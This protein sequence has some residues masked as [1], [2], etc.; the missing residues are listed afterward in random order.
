MTSDPYHVD[1][2][3]AGCVVTD[4]AEKIL[5]ANRYLS[6]NLGFDRAQLNGAGFGSI[7]THA[8]RLILDSYVFPRIETAG[9]CDETLLTMM[10]P[11]GERIPVVVNG[12]V[13]R[14]DQ[15]LVSWSIVRAEKRHQLHDA[16]KRAR[17]LFEGRANALKKLAATD[18]LTGLYNRREFFSQ[19]GLVFRSSMLTGSSVS[20]LMVDVD[21]F[22]RVNDTYGHATGDEMLRQLANRFRSTCRSGELVARFGGEEFVIAVEGM[23]PTATIH[24]AQRM[25]AAAGQVR[26]PD[27]P[28]TVSIGI[29]LRY[30]GA[31]KS[32]LETL[33]DADRALYAAKEAGRNRICLADGDT[34]TEIE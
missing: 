17:D 27:H 4:S 21:Y 15:G 1:M 19:A 11:D 6:D 9:R 13:H 12:Q 29:G 33:E 23:S 30:G 2:F 26:T 8:S 20:L 28:L 34:V 14:Q 16:L 7:F 25:H 31:D 5:F 3:P 24:F 18:E 32:L 10:T 22:K